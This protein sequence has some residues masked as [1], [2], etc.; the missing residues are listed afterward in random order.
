MRARLKTFALKYPKKVASALYVEAQIIMTESK[1]RT[2][3]APDG[4]TLRS[5]GMVSKP[6]I[7]PGGNMSVTLSFGGAAQAYALA[8]HEHMS[9]H[10]PYSWMVAELVG[11]GINWNA[12]GTGPQFLAGPINEAYPAFPTRIARRISFGGKGVA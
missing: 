8:V 6:D 1:K 4:G 3:V 12:D 11:N 5:S 9:E 2:P 10:S 7:Q